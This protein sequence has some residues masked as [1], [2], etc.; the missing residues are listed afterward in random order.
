MR[1]TRDRSCRDRAFRRSEMRGP[2]GLHRP[3]CATPKP[4]AHGFRSP[5]TSAW[6]SDPIAERSI[7]ASPTCGS[8]PMRTFAAAQTV[9][10]AQGN[11]FGS[12]MHR[13][14]ACANSPI[15]SRPVRCESPSLPHVAAPN[16]ATES[17]F[18]W[19]PATATVCRSRAAAAQL[20]TPFPARHDGTTSRLTRRTCG[21]VTRSCTTRQVQA[22]RV[23]RRESETEVRSCGVAIVLSRP[24]PAAAP[25]CAWCRYRPLWR[26]GPDP[27]SDLE[28][29][30]WLSRA[31]ACATRSPHLLR[32]LHGPPNRQGIRLRGV[33]RR[34][35]RFVGPG[36]DMRLVMPPGKL[37]G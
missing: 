25:D 9:G 32:R 11:S 2:I 26:M 13:V 17:A 29:I 3:L 10:R 36:A 28:L 34:T 21:G 31:R 16:Y 22:E 19:R 30:N 27:K 12:S 8:R 23:P 20:R 7:E 24:E 1:G 35:R 5:R 4:A 15:D 6:S 37:V 33:R 14:N 18:G